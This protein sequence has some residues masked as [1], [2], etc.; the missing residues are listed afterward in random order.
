M[1][2]RGGFGGRGGGGRGGGRGMWQREGLER[3]GP[4]IV[5]PGP[6]PKYPNL[7]SPPDL[8]SDEEALVVLNRRMT[9]YWRT[10]CF[11]LRPSARVGPASSSST[12]SAQ[13]ASC[14]SFDSVWSAVGSS[15][16][17]PVAAWDASLTGRPVGSGAEL[18]ALSRQKEELLAFCGLEAFPAELTS[19][20]RIIRPAAARRAATR[21]ADAAERNRKL[22]DM[23]NKE[24][25]GQATADSSA[26]IAQPETTIDEDAL[27]GDEPE[28]FGGDDYAHDYNGDEENDEALDDGGDDDGI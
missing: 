23:E 22:R 25:S 26:A 15:S 13:P 5:D 12:S 3:Q 7:L 16:S 11:Y 24:E 27:F 28:E 10:S 4:V 20:D 14:F 17:A 18:V 1:A 6:F 9:N 19:L 2:G 21:A 8:T